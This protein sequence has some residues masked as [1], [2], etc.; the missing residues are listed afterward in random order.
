MTNTLENASTASSTDFVGV[1]V[2][3]VIAAADELA[4]G[5]RYVRAASLLDATTATGRSRTLLALASAEVAM[6]SD[7]SLRS[8]TAAARL[9]TAELAAAAADLDPGTRWD[10]SFLRLRQ[11]YLGQI[12]RDGTFQPGP[13]G[14]DPNLLA[15]LRRRTSDLLA[16]APDG[17]RRGWAHMYLGLV[18]DNLHGER[19]AAPASYE[20]ALRAGEACGVDGPG[21][22]LL[23]REALRHLG[24]H[25]HDNGDHALALVRW[26]RAAELGA[27][28]GAV[29]GTLAQ[30][31]LLAVLARDAGNEAG[32]TLLAGE[33]VR[34]AAAIGAV[35]I[36]A[37][38]TAF[39]SGVDPTAPPENA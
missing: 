6:A 15:D 39:L 30:Q 16:Q 23:A 11:D 1:P 22:D 8:D 13:S 20:A 37:Q 26:A 7:Y 32:A 3:E 4:R 5:G 10:L 34:W 28:A 19:D 24:D 9:R 33:I 38:A 36:E 27:R 31:L 12:I 25:D 35:N 17:V 29:P 2:D 14:K 18:A 21:D